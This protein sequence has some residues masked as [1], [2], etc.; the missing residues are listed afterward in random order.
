[1]S[2]LSFM[3]N[4]LSKPVVFTGA[5][6]PLG[7]LRTDGKENLLTAVEIAAAKK[8]GKAIVPEVCVYFDSYLFRGNRTSKID[9]QQFRA[10]DSKNYPPLAKAGV[11]IDYNTEFIT[12]VDNN[13][14]FSVNCQIDTNVVILKIFPGINRSIFEAIA[15]IKK[16]KGMVIESFGS[17]N[18]PD[19]PWLQKC[20]GKTVE[21][22]IVVLNVSQCAG[23]KVNMGH[24]E[25]SIGLL[26]S[27]VVSGY[28][29]T[30]E[31]AITKMMY[32][33][34]QGFNYSKTT[35]MLNKNLKGEI[36]V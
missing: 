16:L 7:T 26:R 6:L 10:F 30:T 24:Y 27:G 13:G 35:G 11:E 8:N 28:D 25:T 17:G 36:T 34:G 18:V 15:G 5:Q 29:M 2:A 3:L 23:G 1:A 9:S 32:L 31:A 12:K 22:G 33:L 19:Y 4:N 20:I 14:K 21:K